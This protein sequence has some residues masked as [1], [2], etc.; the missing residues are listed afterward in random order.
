M[1]A[2]VDV[3]ER[4][5]ARVGATIRAA[6]KRVPWTQ[7]ELARAAH[8][9]PNTVVAIESGREVRPSNLRDVMDAL[10]IPSA[11][12]VDEDDD[13]ERARDVDLAVN[14]VTRWLQGAAPS[15]RREFIRELM[16]LAAS[17][18]RV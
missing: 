11:Y 4:R 13:A 9:A 17:H 7:A 3:D 14:L 10:Q 8:V 18:P 2:V 5:R 6:R 15:Q 16:Q 12:A 1:T